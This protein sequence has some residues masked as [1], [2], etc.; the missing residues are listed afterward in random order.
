MTEKGP[1]HVRSVEAF[2]EWRIHGAPFRSEYGVDMEEIFE[3]RMEWSG[4]G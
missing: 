4:F 2:M 1:G 3:N